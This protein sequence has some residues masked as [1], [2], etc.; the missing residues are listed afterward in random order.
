MQK[1][2]EAIQDD[3]SMD[4]TSQNLSLDDC[5]SDLDIGNEEV[6]DLLHEI[7]CKAIQDASFNENMNK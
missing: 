3:S 5:N 6:S 2:D 7:Q 4:R 1:E